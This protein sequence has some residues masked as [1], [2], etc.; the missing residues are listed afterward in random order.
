M[1][2]RLQGC[3]K[4]DPMDGGGRIVPGA[5]IEYDYMDIGGKVTSGTVTEG[6]QEAQ[7]P[8]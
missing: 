4:Y 2:V 1:D 6:R 3:R 7:M 8:R 5:T